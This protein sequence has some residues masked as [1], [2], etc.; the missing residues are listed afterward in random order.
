MTAKKLLGSS[1]WVI[2][3]NQIA[4]VFQSNDAAILLGYL[5]DR[6]S[7]YSA[8][9]EEKKKK[10]NGWFFCE[11]T[12]IQK[13]TVC[14]PHIQRKWFK[15]FEEIGLVQIKLKGVPPKRYFKINEKVLNSLMDSKC[16]PG[17]HLNVNPV[18]IQM[19]TGLTHNSNNRVN[20]NRVEDN[21]STNIV[22]PK[23]NGHSSLKNV[24][25]SKYLKL[26]TKLS[27]IIQTKKK[28]THTNSQIKSW[29]EE[30]RKLT[31]VNKV[32]YSRQKKALK[33]YKKA[34]GGKYIPVIE[35]G[36]SFR[37]K[38][39]KLEDA[40]SREENNFV[41]SNTFGYKGEYKV[42][43]KATTL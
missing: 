39:I 10:F 27:K 26:A 30:F 8:K 11:A 15:V 14:S 32:N 20:K 25:T 41:Q 42:K 31:S 34:I 36:K 4:N 33:W 12:K 13:G 6:D 40:M 43:K 28:V 5:C 2:R 23:I 17:E 21:S 22:E 37:E 18:N 9:S 35:S 19:S 16:Q 7:F 38:F 29:A 3:S 1:A 24:D